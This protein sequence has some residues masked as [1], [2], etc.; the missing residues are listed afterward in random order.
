MHKSNQSKPAFFFC[1]H[2]WHLP[3]ICLIFHDCKKKTS[4][5]TR[6]KSVTNLDILFSSLL[7]KGQST[8][9]FHMCRDSLML[10]KQSS[11][12]CIAPQTSWKSCK[13]TLKMAGSFPLGEWAFKANKAVGENHITILKSE[14]AHDRNLYSFALKFP[15][16]YDCSKTKTKLCCPIQKPYHKPWKWDCGDL[17]R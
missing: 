3:N 14:L 15:P 5:L 8:T 6:K 4:I 10:K 16:S 7:W 1:S 11:E 13:Q 12:D 17:F 9:A 2:F